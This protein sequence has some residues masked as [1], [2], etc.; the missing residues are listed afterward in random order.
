MGNLCVRD[1]GEEA[2]TKTLFVVGRDY[3]ELGQET[4]GEGIKRTSA[5]KASITRAQLE[6]KREE[7]WKKRTTGRRTT[8]YTI[9]TAVETDHL[10][11]AYLLEA[12]SIVPLNNSIT[13]CKDSDGVVYEVPIFVI[14]NPVEFFSKKTKKT[15]PKPPVEEI[16]H[17][18][19][20]R[21]GKETDVQIQIESEKTVRELKEKY[22]AAETID[23]EKVRLIFSGKEMKDQENIAFYDVRNTMVVQAFLRQ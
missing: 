16:I 23:V 14:N 20:R 8:W 19:I 6:R 4:A 11:A 12:V 7:F 15:R 2:A 22:S 1:D 18:K 5:W 17:F 9:R 3:E 10:T 13:R 21:P